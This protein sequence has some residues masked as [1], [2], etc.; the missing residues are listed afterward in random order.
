MKTLRC[1]QAGLLAVGVLLAR[2]HGE[3]QVPPSLVVSNV[4]NGSVVGAVPG[5]AI[6]VN[7]HG[8]LST[9]FAWSLTN[10]SGDSVLTNGSM[11]YIVD[12]G[13]GIGVGGTFSFPFLAAK[14]GD[15]TLSFQYARVNAPPESTFSVT[16]HVTAPPPRLSI[17]LESAS[18][19]ISWPILGSTNFFLEGSSNLAPAQWA[20]LNVLPLQEGTNYIV[21]LGAVGGSLYFRLR[22]SPN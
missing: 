6:L 9:G 15:T 19:V 12:P 17:E 18:V 10:L 14:V 22:Q 7:L 13:G 20:A 11:V 4:D 3:A 1:F 5:Q 16:I 21:K 8:N 2:A